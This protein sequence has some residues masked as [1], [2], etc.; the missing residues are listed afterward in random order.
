MMK[1]ILSAGGEALTIEYTQSGNQYEVAVNDQT[2]TIQLLS[3]SDEALTLLVEGKPLHV[4]VASDG[5]RTLVAI[6]GQVY[7]FTQVQERKSQTR[8]R[9]A[10]RL[11]PQV[12]SPMPGK[13][14]Q[15]LVAEGATVESGEALVLLEAMKM[16]NT[17]SAE[18]TARV[19][20]VHV[21]PGDLVELGQ[22]LVE[23]EF[24]EP[25]VA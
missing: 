25:A 2:R 18:G 13:I 4:H 1:T 14:L 24:T 19:K 21:T 5:T 17:L 6:A 23:L 12:R 7:E 22:I 9:E 11:D 3:V 10:G 20:K 8:Q 16:E 15:V